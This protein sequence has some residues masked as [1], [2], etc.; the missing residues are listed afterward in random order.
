M[1]IWVDGMPRLFN[2]VN[3][4]DGQDS[5]LQSVLF[6]S[7][8]WRWHGTLNRALRINEIQDSGTRTACMKH[9]SIFPEQGSPQLIYTACSGA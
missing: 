7:W 1:L 8:F 9:I 3:V 6:L 2:Y 5:P 4:L